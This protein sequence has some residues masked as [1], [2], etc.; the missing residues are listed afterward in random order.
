MS[1]E[2]D[3]SFMRTMLWPG[4]QMFES[5]MAMTRAT[6]TAFGAP[7]ATRE[8][9]TPVST[10]PDIGA[11]EERPEWET[12][13]SVDDVAEIEVGD[14]VTFTK[15]VGD[16]DVRRFAAASGD[17]NPIHL[18]DE[19]ASETRFGGRIAHG[20][21]VGGLISAALARLPGTVVYLSQDL[22][23]LAPVDL[24]SEL[25]ATCR[26]AENLG[27]GRYRLTTIVEIDGQ[28]CIDGEAVVLIEG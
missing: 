15:P 4:S 23:F 19:A 12:D 9:S 20:T 10:G 6:M 11:G 16:T 28:T 2:Y 27:D 26:I 21:L 3:G 1:S 7:P 22:E 18:D 17:T 14:E 8:S 13:R 25:T 5:A 24:E